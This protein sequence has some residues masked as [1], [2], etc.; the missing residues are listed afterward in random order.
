MMKRFLIVCIVFFLGAAFPPGCH[1]GATPPD[2]LNI[3]LLG[4]S[5]GVDCTEHL[6]ALLKEAGITNV[7]IGRFIKGN[8]SLEERWNLAFQP[9]V[10]LECAPGETE[11]VRRQ[12]TMPEIFGE[13]PWDIVIFQ[14][15]LENEGRYETIQPWLDRLVNLVREEMLTRYGRS[16]ELW[17]N[18]FWPIS[19]LLEGKPEK[20]L[21]T[22]RLSFYGGSSRKMYKAY[23][24]TARKVVRRTA[25]SR[26]IPSGATIMALRSSPLNEPG[27][28]EFTRDGYH[29]SF[30]AG[31][32]AAACT[33]FESLITPRYGVSVVGNA[34]RLPDLVTPVTDANAEALQRAARRSV[35]KFR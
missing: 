34:L 29:L 28:K 12:A 6:P 22:Y 25:V 5:Y 1:A 20:E 16:P 18:C 3:L 14:T 8:C 4:H 10:Y 30:G 27:I 19:V 2:S 23:V 11:Y 7:R 17:W 9:S 13:R 26:I 33:V 24:K 31:R 21:P 32:Y 35:R 15:S